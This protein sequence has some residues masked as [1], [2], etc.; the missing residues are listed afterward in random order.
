MVANVSC[1]HNVNLSTLFTTDKHMKH[2]S[3]KAMKKVLY[4]GD[5]SKIQDWKLNHV[6]PPIQFISLKE[7]EGYPLII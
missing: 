1:I 7:G 3:I 2:I 5:P 6:R 4:S